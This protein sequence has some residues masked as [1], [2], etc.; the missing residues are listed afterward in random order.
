MR[1]FASLWV[2][3][4]GLISTS[5]AAATGSRL[6]DLQWQQ[7]SQEICDVAPYKS[8]N[9]DL[10]LCDKPRN[11]PGHETEECHLSFWAGSDASAQIYF[12]RFT[13]H[14]TQAIVMYGASCESHADSFGGMA[15][16]KVVDQRLQLLRYYPGARYVDCAV[17]LSRGSEFQTPHCF[18]S[19]SGQGELNEAFGP[20]RFAPDGQV[21]LEEWLEAGNIDRHLTT[22]IECEK[23]GPV[24][25]HLIGV[26]L[27]QS[28]TNV[29][30]EA[31]SI[32]PASSKRACDRYRKRQFNA[33]EKKLRAMSLVATTQAFIR[34]GEN[35][36]VKVIVRFHA[37]DSRGK[38]EVTS[39]SVPQQ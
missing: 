2:A 12:G 4:L 7:L 25:H 22:M 34:P 8:D 5:A 30:V 16:F 14:E 29:V 24:L 23:S 27:D 13:A 28:N 37:P 31:A 35:K 11:Y 38:F 39:E 6:S 15:L 1:V 20:L 9:G 10:W 19:S 36:Y 18:G 32:D 26:G 17:P 33:E 21:H 3:L